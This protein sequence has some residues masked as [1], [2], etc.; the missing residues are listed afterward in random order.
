MYVIR[1][2]RMLTDVLIDLM[3][4]FIILVRL[5]CLKRFSGRVIVRFT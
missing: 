5:L 3:Y 2:H 4:A 1:S